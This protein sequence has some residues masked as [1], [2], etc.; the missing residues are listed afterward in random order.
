MYET[1]ETH[2]VDGPKV[3]FNTRQLP[4]HLHW[5]K[6]IIF[7]LQP[8]QCSIPKYICNQKWREQLT[9][10]KYALSSME[11]YD[12]SLVEALWDVE[13]PRVT[14]LSSAYLFPPFM[15]WWSVSE[16]SSKSCTWMHVLSLGAKNLKSSLQNSFMV[17]LRGAF[18]CQGNICVSAF[19]QAGRFDTSL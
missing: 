19:F 11:Q 3:W 2:E 18:C 1:L 17:L 9:R 6:F 5:I 10:Q 8:E 4:K 14:I 7:I 15:E 16:V 13:M 12:A